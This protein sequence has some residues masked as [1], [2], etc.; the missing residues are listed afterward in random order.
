[1][2]FT[3]IIIPLLNFLVSILLG[4]YIGRKGSI[5]MTIF[6]YIISIS[7]LI[8]SFFLNLKYDR[9]IY[10]PLYSWIT[11]GT[12][13]LNLILLI[14][15]LTLSMF[16]LVL[17]VSTIVHIYSIEYMYNDPHLQRFIS[18]LSLFTFFMLILV[19]SN[20]F[21]Q[22]FVGWEGVGLCS[23]LLIS[24]WYTR[25]SA[26][27][28]AIKAIFFNRIGDCGLI[29]AIMTLFYYTHS[30]DFGINFNLISYIRLETISFFIFEVYA[31]DFII[32]FMLLATIGKSAQFFLH[33]WL[34]DAM[35][36]PT[37]VSALIHAATMVTAGIFLLIRCSYI[38]SYSN[39]YTY[40]T[41][42]ISIL[43]IL[44]ASTVGIFQND[45]KKIIAYSTCSQLGYMLMGCAFL[46][47]N[48]A[49]F[50]LFNHGFFK[51]LLFLSAGLIIHNMNDE[52][53]LRKLGG[54]LHFM[55][56]TYTFFFIGSCSLVG[57][58]FLSGYY[59]K[60]FILETLYIY[61]NIDNIFAYHITSFSIF[62][63]TFYS[64]RLL[65]FTFYV[66]PNGFRSSYKNYISNTFEAKTPTLILL[67]LLAILSIF[68]GFLYKEIFIGFGSNYYLFSIYTNPTSVYNTYYIDHL[69]DMKYLPF[70]YI[71]VGIIST[72]FCVIFNKHISILILSNIFLYKSYIFFN[73]AWFL[74][75]FYYLIGLMFKQM[76]YW[77][78]VFDKTFLE[79]TGPMF[80]HNWLMNNTNRFNFYTRIYFLDNLIIV[81]FLIS[82]LL[83]IIYFTL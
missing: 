19:S 26:T 64:F 28:S 62:L 41:Y 79:A 10:I 16:F 57:F 82:V 25:L 70:L 22:L 58:P 32:F 21:I 83:I 33:V 65:F 74:N 29:V 60:D 50:H 2:L 13:D 53:D 52:Q 30:F 76:S 48:E 55:P 71:T 40:I 18:Y 49:F 59:S 20:N 15:S 75:Q 3:I 67:G 73:Q 46:N 17:V 51:A 80:L 6:L 14:D 78:F 47:F 72:I 39:L 8:Y 7:I 27:K 66:N 77:C 37:P 34:A 56:I 38:F 11:S 54:L 81:T 44:F 36:G 23:Y 69:F 12:F 24:F 1:M 43:T 42:N 35:E 61:N 45:I 9:T 4:R 5:F 68:S 63:T 31:I